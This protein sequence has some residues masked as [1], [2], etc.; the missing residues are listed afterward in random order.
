MA[1]REINAVCLAAPSL[2]SVLALFVLCFSVLFMSV[3]PVA[4]LGNEVW[5][6]L[7]FTRSNHGRQN[8]GLLTL[9]EFISVSFAA[10]SF[11]FVQGVPVQGLSAGFRS[12]VLYACL[13]GLCE[14]RG[15]ESTW[16]VWQQIFG[17]YEI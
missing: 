17:G 4:V 14:Y 13:I 2:V 6:T 16:R 10:P 8:P 9:E 5:C 1:L 12:M 3:T 15:G 11:L 7:Y